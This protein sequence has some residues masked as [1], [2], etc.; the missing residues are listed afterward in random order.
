MTS[1]RYGAAAISLLM[2]C[3]CASSSSGELRAPRGAERITYNNWPDAIRLFN[4]TAE[5]VI[6]P[7]IGR[8]MRYGYV[9]GENLLWDDPKLHGQGGATADVKRWRN[10]GGEKV[11]PWPQDDW[12]KRAGR[13][14]PPPIEVDQ[15][16]H[17][18]E[19]IGD[20]TVRMTSP[21]LPGYG[22][23]VSRTISLSESGSRVTMNIEFTPTGEG[24]VAPAVP[25]SVAQLRVPNVMMARLVSDRGYKPLAPFDWRIVQRID[26]R[27]IALKRSTERAEKIGI[28]ADL[29]IWVKGGTFLVQRNVSAT[30]NDFAPA[31][32][33]QIFSQKGESTY[34]EYE[35]VAPRGARSLTVTWQLHDL[36][37]DS[38][39]PAAIAGY[40]RNL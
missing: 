23:R 15:Q 10:F 29:L 36:P 33:A 39:A 12:A 18:A 24:D 28:D 32:R 26:G 25:W 7:S 2:I 16:P 31:E 14:W 22:V 4:D 11:W 40:L 1:D 37:R 30:S 27:T 21:P 13:A 35:F 19:I 5:V 6:V 9:G 17:E 3:G 20:R 8:V 34:V 38:A